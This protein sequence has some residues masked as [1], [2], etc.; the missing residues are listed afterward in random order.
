MLTTL[1][2]TPAQ[3]RIRESLGNGASKADRIS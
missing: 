3:H 2:L 1:Q